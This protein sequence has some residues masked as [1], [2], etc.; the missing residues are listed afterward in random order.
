MV[1][2]S[3]MPFFYGNVDFDGRGNVGHVAFF[4]SI[5]GMNG[6]FEPVDRPRWDKIL[7]FDRVHGIVARRHEGFLRKE[8]CTMM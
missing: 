4:K 1:I 5:W 8:E 6:V 7:G 3:T 2:S